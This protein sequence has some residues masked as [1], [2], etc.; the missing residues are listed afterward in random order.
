MSTRNVYFAQF[1]QYAV[2]PV[3]SSEVIEA[4]GDRSVIILDGRRAQYE[5]ARIAAYVARERGYVGYTLHRGR[6][7]GHSTK[8]PLALVHRYDV[9]DLIDSVIG[10]ADTAQGAADLFVR[11]MID[12]ERDGG[13]RPVYSYDHKKGVAR[14]YTV[15]TRESMGWAGTSYTS[16]NEVREVVSAMVIKGIKGEKND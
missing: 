7:N 16:F 14:P 15:Y 11:R 10:H 12:W 4:N 13:M 5:N 1:Y 2:W 9:Y 3:G 8:T 6:I